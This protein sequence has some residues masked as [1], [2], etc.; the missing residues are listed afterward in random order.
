MW[1]S[2]QPQTDLPGTS[3]AQTPGAPLNPA[4]TTGTMRSGSP[5]FRDLARLGAGL[6]VK[7]EISGDEDLLIDGTVEGGITLQSHRLT[8][9]STAQLSSNVVA[10][11]VVIH[12]EVGGNLRV[13]DRVEI[14]KDSAVIG[15]ITTARISIE[16]GA[17]FKGRIE[18]D[19]GNPPMTEDLEAARVPV[20]ISTI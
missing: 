4:N 13:R 10:R 15:D 14:K 18:I 12:G 1:T 11:E 3:R 7:G 9:G 17:Y 16:D 2:K 6:V 20:A 5:T 19:R 8:V